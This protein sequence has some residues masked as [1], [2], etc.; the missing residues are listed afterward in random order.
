[1][2]H[3]EQLETKKL[4]HPVLQDRDNFYVSSRALGPLSGGGSGSSA[5]SSSASKASS[6]SAFR[7]APPELKSV[8]L[9]MKHLPSEKG[10][11]AAAAG[12][13]CTE[14]ALTKVLERCVPLKQMSTDIKWKHLDTYFTE[15]ELPP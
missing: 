3:R 15:L 2:R 7:N 11:P 13:V 14:A 1:M 12:P 5:S 4:E 6:D 9:A 8:L 10:L